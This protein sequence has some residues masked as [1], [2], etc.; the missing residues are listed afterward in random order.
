[1][2]QDQLSSYSLVFRIFN[3]ILGISLFQFVEFFFFPSTCQT[4]RRKEL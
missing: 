2:I 1:L 3:S 4:Q